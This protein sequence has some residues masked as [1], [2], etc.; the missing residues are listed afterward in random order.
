MLPPR[1]PPPKRARAED[2][3]GELSLRSA[4]EVRRQME[5][6]DADLGEESSTEGAGFYKGRR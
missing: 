5:T 3:P 6:E 1:P 2:V 4:S